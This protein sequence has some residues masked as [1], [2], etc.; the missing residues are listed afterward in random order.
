MPELHPFVKTTAEARCL[1]PPTRSALAER[2]VATPGCTL[3]PRRRPPTS[4][5]LDNLRRWTLQPASP[6]LE[7][8]AELYQ[9]W[10]PI[11][12]ASAD[13]RDASEARVRTPFP[14]QA[15]GTI[16]KTCNLF[17]RM[18]WDHSIR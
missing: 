4:P 14:A 8:S 18:S 16:K 2:L 11:G 3:P 15:Q 7:T 10:P 17:S 1:D 12:Q 9:R 6:A 13:C 5:A